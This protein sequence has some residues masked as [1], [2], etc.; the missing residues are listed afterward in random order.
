MIAT[1]IRSSSYG[2]HDMCEQKFF[3]GY[4]LGIKEPSNLKADKG[5]VVHKA[6]E[7]MARKKKCLQDGTSS[8]DDDNFGIV[9]AGDITPEWATEKS[10]AYYSKLADHH[11]WTQKDLQ[12]C[13]L[14]VDKT[15]KMNG[16]MF[17]PMRRNVVEPEQRFDFEVNKPWAK[18]DYAL[19]DDKRLTGQLSL[20]GT[21]DLVVEDEPGLI[22]VIDYKTGRRLNWATGEEKTYKKLRYDPQLLLYHYATAQ[23]YPHAEEIFITIIYINDGGPFTLCFDR[24]DFEITER[25]IR[26]KFERIRDTQRPV[27]TKS[28]KCRALCHF[29][30]SQHPEDPSK[31]MCEFF[32]DETRKKGA[33]KVLFER[34]DV[35]K[36]SDY[37][38]GGGRVGQ[39]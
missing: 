9:K 23:L 34:G 37:N 6:M 4:T 1:Y 8:Y 10:F 29:G 35:S 24:S 15:L 28:W 38:E 26:K 11:I 32:K 31:T 30:R 14:W 16:G 19:P 36:I 5:N 22:E 12:D 3:L 33:D 2:T 25:L 21:M 7:L 17:N 39:K 13:H 27:L 20:K 18:Y